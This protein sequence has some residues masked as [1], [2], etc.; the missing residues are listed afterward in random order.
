VFPFARAELDYQ[1]Y[2]CEENVHRLLSRAELAAWEAWAVVVSNR[3]KDALLMR[4]R[5]GRPVDGL[6]HW[7]YHVFAAVL[8]PADGAIALDLDSQL[9][10]PCS[11]GRYLEDTF[12]RDSPARVT[13][14]FRA[15][16][17]AEYVRCLS[18]DRSHMIRDDGSWIWP[19]P[20]WP[21]PGGDSEVRPN[22]M[23]WVDVRRRTPGRLYDADKLASVM[24]ARERK[25][26][27]RMS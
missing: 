9:P 21:A 26:Q 8:D 3:A 14:R 25:S 24:R 15:I 11:L 10:F 6:V 13:A 7:D 4:Q 18:S 12:P 23:H 22:L 20:P 1:P 19:P 17:A 2:Y 5:A 27:R 16:P